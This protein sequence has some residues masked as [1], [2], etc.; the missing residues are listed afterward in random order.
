[1]LY[2]YDQTT[3]NYVKVRWISISFKILIVGLFLIPI[4]GV[5]DK[6]KQEFTEE[7]IMIVMDKQNHFNVDKFVEKINS[8]HFRFPHIVYAQAILETNTFKS[9]IFI[10]NNNLFGMKEAKIRLTTAKGTQSEH[11]YY[12]NWV[13]SIYDYAFYTSTYLSSIKTEDAYYDYL[14][15]NY[16]EDPGYVS[17]LKT[18]VGNIPLDLFK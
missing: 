11:A 18:I 6:S 14:A 8:L 12:D 1:M 4:L 5:N 9:S 10:E 16:A 3:L 13:E 7:E 2:R 15:Q 17:K